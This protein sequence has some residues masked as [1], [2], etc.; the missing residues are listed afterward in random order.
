MRAG[1]DN[2]DL[3]VIFLPY[4]AGGQQTDFVGVG[5]GGAVL[6]AF[7]VD[8]YDGHLG[9]QC[10]QMAHVGLAGCADDGPGVV[11]MDECPA[12]VGNMVV[13]IGVHDQLAVIVFLVQG[14]LY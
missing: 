5:A 13:G 11:I 8:E 14:G 12:G 9:F 10:F 3:A 6:V 2:S 4:Q 1:R 7:A